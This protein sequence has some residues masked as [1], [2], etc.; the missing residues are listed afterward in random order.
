MF[1]FSQHR[2]YTCGGGGGCKQ[3]GNCEKPGQCTY[4]VKESHGGRDTGTKSEG[5]RAWKHHKEAHNSVGNFKGETVVEVAFGHIQVTTVCL[6]AF[7][8]K[9][10]FL[11]CIRN[12][13]NFESLSSSNPSA[14]PSAH[15]FD[16]FISERGLSPLG[17]Q[18]SQVH[19][20]ACSEKLTPALQTCVP[21]SSPCLASN[22]I[23][24]SL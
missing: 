22:S 11:T 6:Q 16:L 8:Q 19:C 20:C 21:L 18:H 17:F 13:H 15:L 3:K 10:P 2:I 1:F 7:I 23:H 4:D 12:S 14:R 9:S 5:L 24:L